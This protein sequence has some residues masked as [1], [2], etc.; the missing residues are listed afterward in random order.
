MRQSPCE[1]LYHDDGTVDDHPKVDRSQAH[2]IG[3][4]TQPL[5]PDKCEQHGQGNRRSDDQCCTNIPQEQ[6]QNSDNEKTPFEQVGLYRRDRLVDE[7]R[8][9][10][11]RVDLDVRGQGLVDLFNPFFDALNDFA[12]VLSPQHHND[13][14]AHL[15]PSLHDDGPLPDL[16]TY[17]H[18]CDVCDRD[19]RARFGLDDDVLEVRERGC[20]TNPSDNVLL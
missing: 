17:G 6:K 19:R 9:I 7:V 18:A 5:H 12:A 16:R 8:L 14:G 20:K 3:R 4:K 10:V 1:V 2:E 11:I 15:P 13:S